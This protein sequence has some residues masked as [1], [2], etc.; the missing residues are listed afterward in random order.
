[1]LYEAAKKPADA[2]WL[3]GW[4]SLKAWGL[5]IAHR[6]G[7]KKAVAAV[8]RKLAV[9]MYA[10]WRDDTVSIFQSGCDGLE[11][12]GVVTGDPEGSDVQPCQRCGRASISCLRQPRASAGNRVTS[13][14]APRPDHRL[15]RL[16]IERV[17]SA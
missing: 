5:Q 2:R 16:M 13:A 1:M 17:K 3:S 11:T 8:A 9:I 14:C 12:V 15:R 4:C 10:M 6:S 7:Y